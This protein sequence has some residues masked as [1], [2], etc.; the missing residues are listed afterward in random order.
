MTRLRAVLGSLL[1]LVVAPGTVTILLPW[2]ITGWE[3]AETP[4]WW[5]PLRVLGWVLIV[6]AA[7]VLLAAFARFALNGLGTPAPVA[8]TRHL[9]VQGLYRHVRNPMYVAVITI[10]AGECLI[11]AR[12]ELVLYTVLA[13]AAMVLFVRGYEEP[14]LERTYGDEY[15]AYREAVPGWVPSLRP[16]TSHLR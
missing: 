8:P 11:L 12:L 3:A 7:P 2:L 4:A 14:V 10:L 15:R 6:A 13:S 9:V 16:S 5:W 1:F